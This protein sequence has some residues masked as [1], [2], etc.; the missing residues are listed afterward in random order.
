[1]GAQILADVAEMR[2]RIRHAKPNRSVWE[3]KL[4]PG[5]MQD[6]ELMAQTTALIAA[7]ASRGVERQLFAGRKAGFLS[8]AQESVLLAAYRLCWRVQCPAHLLAET[9]LD[10]ETIGQGGAEFVLRE[11]EMSDLD[12]LL[13]EL[14]TR[15]AAAAAIIEQ[16]ISANSPQNFTQPEVTP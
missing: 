7:D 9:T 1:M 5:R 3:V 16:L 13:V 6:I 14:D 2:A 8:E 10:P 15:A 11:T 4:G 12:T